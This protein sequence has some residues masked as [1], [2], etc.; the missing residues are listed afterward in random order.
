VAEAGELRKQDGGLVFDL[1]VA[2]LQANDRRK[3][4]LRAE[5]QRSGIDAEALPPLDERVFGGCGGEDR[6]QEPIIT[7][8]GSIP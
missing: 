4:P 1:P 2:D 8:A 6:G 5:E 7:S 3:S